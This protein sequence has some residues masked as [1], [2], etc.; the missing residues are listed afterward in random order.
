[1]G[2]HD[3]GKGDYMT[4]STADFTVIKMEVAERIIGKNFQACLF[5]I[6]KYVI[7]DNTQMNLVNKMIFQLFWY[8][9]FANKF[10]Y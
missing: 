7:Y 9:E 6:G 8:K 5:L 3:R 4:V 2:C 1:L 10:V